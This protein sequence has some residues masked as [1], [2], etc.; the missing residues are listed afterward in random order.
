VRAAWT[1]ALDRATCEVG[2]GVEMPLPEEADSTGVASRNANVYDLIDASLAACTLLAV[3]AALHCEGASIRQLSVE[4]SHMIDDAGWIVTRL[5]QVTGPL[6]D[7]QQTLLVDAADA[8]SVY[9]LLRA[10]SVS[11]VSL[12]NFRDRSP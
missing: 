11:I 3:K 10:G 7:D 5:M 2:R 8:C 6:S 12:E 1:P 4:V 9:R